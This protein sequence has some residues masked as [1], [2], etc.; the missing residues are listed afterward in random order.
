MTDQYENCEN[1]IK[2]NMENVINSYFKQFLNKFE[3]KYYY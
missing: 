2:K 1:N 3:S